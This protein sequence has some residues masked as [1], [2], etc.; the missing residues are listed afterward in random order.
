MCVCNRN[1]MKRTIIIAL[2]LIKHLRGF[3]YE[4]L[5][6]KLCYLPTSVP[7]W[8]ANVFFIIINGCKN[9]WWFILN[10]TLPLPL[11]RMVVLKILPQDNKISMYD[12]RCN[13]CRLCFYNDSNCYWYENLIGTIILPY[14]KN[15]VLLSCMSMNSCSL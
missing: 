15:F 9:H 10:T 7:L 2:I 14:V 1:M 3:G 12:I 4:D 11:T 13:L 6:R 8:Q 5:L